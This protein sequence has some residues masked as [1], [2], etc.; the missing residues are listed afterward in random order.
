MKDNPREPQPDGFLDP[1]RR[2][3]PTAVGVATPPPPRRGRSPQRPS[4]WIR[5][6]IRRA[7]SLT[8]LGAAGVAIGTVLPTGVGLALAIG[9]S[10]AWLTV[11]IARRRR[12][13]LVLV[14]AHPKPGSRAA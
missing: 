4:S 2:F 13:R 10:S 5:R 6:T 1:P 11:R 8:V 12:R 9:L 14:H 3:P 7:V